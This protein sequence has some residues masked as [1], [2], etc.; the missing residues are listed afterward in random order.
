MVEE[1]Q[2]ARRFAPTREN[3]FG[4]TQD[5]KWRRTLE[6]NVSLCSNRSLKSMIMVARRS[7]PQSPSFGKHWSFDEIVQAFEPSQ[8]TVNLTTQWLLESG[9]NGQQIEQSLDRGSLVFNA[10]IGELENLLQTEYFHYSHETKGHNAVA[11]D[12]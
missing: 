5:R 11:C 7:D 1:K 3:C 12:K 6:E 10:T 8:E 9:I 4:S 2:G